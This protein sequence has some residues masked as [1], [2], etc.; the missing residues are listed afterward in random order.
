MESEAMQQKYI[1]ERLLADHDEDL[2]LE[3]KMIPEKVTKVTTNTSSQCVV[4]SSILH[5][6]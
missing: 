4:L 5:S 6:N 1:D 3:V 2:G